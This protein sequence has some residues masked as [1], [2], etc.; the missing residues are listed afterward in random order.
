MVCHHAAQASVSVSVRE[1]ALDASVNIM[2][3]IYLLEAAR[4]LGARFV[5]ASTGGALYGEVPEGKLAAVDTPAAPFSPYACSKAAFE[6]YLRAYGAAHQLP[7][8]ILRYG[9]VYGPRQDPHGE[10]GVVA[11]FAQRLLRGDVIQV[12]A[13]QQVGDAGCVRDY[14]FVD[15]VV[16]AN[17]L[18]LSG[19]LDGTMLNVGT[20]IG[21]STQQIA[22]Q[23]ITALSVP[24]EAKPGPYREGDLERSVLDA[25]PFRELV[26]EPV[27]LKEGIAK[28]AQWFQA[29]HEVKS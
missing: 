18:A 1:P 11:I 4:Q 27:S 7:Y 26:G 16:K 28:T 24:T 25:A 21:S 6:Y 19:E 12:N 17:L 29:Q 8:V 22:E 13:R 23:M 14:V 9:N 2:G 20:G 3:S 5:F 15:D 10:A